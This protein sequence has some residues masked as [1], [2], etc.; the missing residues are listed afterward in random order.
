MSESREQTVEMSAPETLSGIFF[1]PGRTYEA[2]RARPRF[3]VVAV[4]SLLIFMAF[5]L[6]YMTRVGYEN[7]VNA[8]IELRSQKTDVSEE[9]KAKGHDIQMKPVV[10]A[11]RYF[12]PVI[13]FA[14]IIA[15]GAALYLLGV[16]ALG[17]KISYKQALAVWCYSSFPP[18]LIAMVANI[19]IL[20]LRPPDAG[21]YSAVARGAGGL[22]HANPGAF[23]PS[24]A[25]PL[26]VTA[27]G[28]FDLF[29][30]Y[31]LFLAAL[32]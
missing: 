21:D 2:L 12:S 26:F 24:D 9:D 8:E 30:I 6:L 4:L 27:L 23:M 13:V 25:S 18:L 10:K 29:A 32:G 17:K 14:I 20:L 16:L 5:Y 15:A 19:I 7:I 31:G 11:I 28:I 22:V 1:E 3:L